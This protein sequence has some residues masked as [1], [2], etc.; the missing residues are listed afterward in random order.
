MVVWGLPKTL[1]GIRSKWPLDTH[2]CFSRDRLYE[3]LDLQAGPVFF[4]IVILD[5]SMQFDHE[6]MQ[7]LISRGQVRR[8]VICSESL[9][10][11]NFIHD[12]VQYTCKILTTYKTCLL[13]LST[14]ESS[15]APQ[16]MVDNTRRFL[17]VEDTVGRTSCDMT[18]ILNRYIL[19]VR[20]YSSYHS[21][22]CNQYSYVRLS[23]KA[24]RNL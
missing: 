19:G 20:L 16:E 3:V 10:N 6:L 24:N 21:G 18:S 11:G 9:H 1:E 8:I 5:S 14:Y 7:N 15:K 12:K 4:I 17:A 22:E 2:F 23:G 13:V